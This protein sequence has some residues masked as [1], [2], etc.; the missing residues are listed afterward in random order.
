MY[1]VG[2]FKRVGEKLQD[3]LRFIARRLGFVRLNRRA[4]HTADQDHDKCYRRC[5][6]DPVPTNGVEPCNAW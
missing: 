4:R 3:R 2:L 6:T 1:R 5:E